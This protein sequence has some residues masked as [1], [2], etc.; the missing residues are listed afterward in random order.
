MPT[1]TD[2]T[3]GT[4]GCV[5]AGRLAENPNVTVLVVEAGVSYTKDIEVIS[6][7]ARAFELRGSKWDWGY[8]TT[9]IDRPDYTRVE[10]PNS[11]G[12][13]LGGSSAENYFTWIRGSAATFDD[14]AA[15]GGDEWTWA[16]CKEYFDKP[17]TFHDDNN[18]FPKHLQHIGTSGPLNVAPADLLPEAAPFRDALKMAWASK[19]QLINDE[20]YDGEM[21]GVRKIRALRIPFQLS[22]EL[23][24][25]TLLPNYSR[26]CPNRELLA[27][28]V[29]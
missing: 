14:W 13:V 7:P 24:G 5:V 10:K 22:R 15:Y 8:K 28:I 27:D 20:I 19:G 21:H 17:A 1:L 3:G 29:G 6:T 11:R 26:H 23:S 12:K 9:M 18:V 16:K 2:L 25:A 4:A